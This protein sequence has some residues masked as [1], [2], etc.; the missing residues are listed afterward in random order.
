MGEY[1]IE[2]L[3]RILPSPFQKPVKVSTLFD[4]VKIRHGPDLGF[5]NI[6]IANPVVRY[7]ADIGT[8]HERLEKHMDAVSLVRLVQLVRRGLVIVLVVHLLAQ[9]VQAVDLVKD[10]TQSDVGVITRTPRARGLERDGRIYAGVDNIGLGNGDDLETLG[11]YVVPRFVEF[12]G[13]RLAPYGGI[14]T[15]ST[16]E[17]SKSGLHVVRIQNRC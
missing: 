2:I 16:V 7:D 3:N 5:R 6:L 12:W 10:F 13:R 1:L 11:G 17:R 4:Y 9:L 8:A 15:K 14:V